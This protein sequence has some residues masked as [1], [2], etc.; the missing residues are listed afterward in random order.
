MFSDGWTQNV[1][2]CQSDHLE[3][4]PSPQPPEQELSTAERHAAK[5]AKARLELAAHRAE[6]GQIGK[7]GCIQIEE[8]KQRKEIEKVA[9]EEFF[10][11]AK[12]L[13][14]SSFPK[15]FLQLLKEYD[16]KFT[17]DF[18]PEEEPLPCDRQKA[19]QMGIAHGK[20]CALLKM[21]KELEVMD[22]LNEL[23]DHCFKDWTQAL[24]AGKTCNNKLALDGIRLVDQIAKTMPKKKL[25]KGQYD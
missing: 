8:Q 17:K 22:Y 9:R 18:S 12:K 13:F 15:L 3:T 21:A 25:F 4:S 24:F 5:V 16:V 23:S 6:A 20:L 2:N 14:L 19:K 10:I 1:L 11:P 7:I